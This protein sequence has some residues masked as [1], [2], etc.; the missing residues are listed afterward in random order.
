MK[1]FKNELRKRDFVV[2]A[3]CFLKPETDAA[4]IRY[5]AETLHDHVDGIVLTDNQ[6]G[7]THMSTIAAARLMLDNDVDP[8]VQLSCRNR[9]RIGLVADMLGACALGVSSLLLVLGNRVPE[10]ITPRPK[11]MLDMKVDDL[12]GTAA[13][14][15][16]DEQLKFTTDLLIGST[17]SPHAPKADWKANQISSKVDAGA[18]FLIAHTNMNIGLLRKF[19]GQLIAVG[20]TRRASF[21]VSSVILTSA[22]DA[23]WL[24]DHRFNVKIPDPI[25][26]R[27]ENAKNQREEGLAI[28]AE[29]LS[30]LATIPGV[31]G[32]NIIASTDLAMI[33][34]VIKAADLGKD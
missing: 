24:R 34:E 33:P 20:L 19:M 14:M 3:E 30:Q 7:Q 8:I 18:Q 22:D 4:S 1:I 27:L 17:L 26:H 25:V 31:S 32:A 9:N 6:H 10:S 21:I 11:A 12:I 2:T 15:K 13:N 5:Q 28:C 29:H 23:R 16:S